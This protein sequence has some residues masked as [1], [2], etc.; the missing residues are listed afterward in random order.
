MTSERKSMHNIKTLGALLDGRRARTPSGALQ[1][2]SSLANERERLR[3]ELERGERRRAEIEARLEEIAVKEQW[4]ESVLDGARQATS[5]RPVPLAAPP[6][7]V[8]TRELNY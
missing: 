2:L 8:R 6:R 7:Q 3:N 4:L 5:A 1:E